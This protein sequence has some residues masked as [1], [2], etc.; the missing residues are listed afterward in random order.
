MPCVTATQAGRRY[1]VEFGSAM[2]AYSVLV[3]ATALYLNAHP[4]N[5]WRFEIAVAPVVAVGFALVAF[6]RFFGTLD[7][8]QRKIHVDAFIFSALAT[9]LITFAYGFLE[10]V[11]LPHFDYTFVLP[12][13]IA[14]WGVGAAVAHRRY[15]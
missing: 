14:L 12:L 4:G 2:F 10:G 5:P 8:L 1:L 9:G 15:S 3:I 13:M 6:M 7:E 11:G